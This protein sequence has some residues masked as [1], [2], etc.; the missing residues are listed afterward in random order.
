VLASALGK[1]AIDHPH[2]EDSNTGTMRQ[3][4]DGGYLSNRP[5]RE[6]L[7]AHRTYWMGYFGKNR[8]GINREG[9]V[10]VGGNDIQLLRPMD[11]P[12]DKDLIETKR[13]Y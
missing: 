8:S 3:L 13:L 12:K 9:G 10:E 1:Y 5:L 6:L 2:I 7:T 4:W 11:I